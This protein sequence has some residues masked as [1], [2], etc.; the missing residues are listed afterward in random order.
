MIADRVRWPVKAWDDGISSRRAWLAAKNSI[1][2]FDR[3]LFGGFQHQYRRLLTRELTDCGRIL[4]V[5]CG[6]D[7]P[8]RWIS[9]SQGYDFTVGVDISEADLNESRRL[10]IH[11]CLVVLD[12]STL[13]RAFKSRSFDC[14]LASDVIEHLEKEQGLRLLDDMERVARR[15]VVV[16]TPNGFLEQPP[17]EDNPWQEHRSGWTVSEF[18]DRGY[19]VLG[20]NGWRPLRT[21][22]A[23]IAF[24]PAKLWH[25]I[26][27]LTQPLA[28]RYPTL[29]FQ[30]LAVKDL[31]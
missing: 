4:D 2:S 17:D 27:L 19:R 1:R 30:L 29:A 11:D 10:G 21:M 14:V 16:F 18:R 13:G 7:S 26:S 6:R 28:Q 20:V 5:G 25:R 12:I 31:R 24:R 15:H 3:A 22:Y 8:I 9:D 23:E